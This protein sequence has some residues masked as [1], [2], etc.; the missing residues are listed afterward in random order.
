MARLRLVLAL[1]LAGAVSL[2]AGLGLF[3]LVSQTPCQGEQLSCNIDDAV[4][5]YASMIWTGLG[6]AV[7]CIAL[8]FAKRRKAL[9]VAAM[10]L[11]APLLLFA[12]GDLLEGWRYVGVYP[13]ADFRSFI[14]KFAPP[15]TVV[16]VQYLIMRIAV[17]RSMG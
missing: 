5:G 16:L 6:L 4:G 9:A 2:G 17:A 7:F 15:A 10:I 11:I 14:A 13:Y 8:L 3:W 12:G 1:L